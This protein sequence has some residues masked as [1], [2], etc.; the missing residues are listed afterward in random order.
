M[1]FDRLMNENEN[2]GG[3]DRRH[4]FGWYQSYGRIVVLA[5]QITGWA[6]KTLRA[7]DVL[8]STDRVI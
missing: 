5:P 2:Q 3:H 7:A 8:S 4:T 1:S 6:R